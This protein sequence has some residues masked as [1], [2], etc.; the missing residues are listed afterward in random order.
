MSKFASLI[1]MIGVT[2]LVAGCQPGPGLSG[3]PAPSSDIRL[4]HDVDTIEDVVPRSATLEM[5]LRSQ[6]LSPDFTA[7]FVSAVREEFNPR[8]LRANQPYRITRTLDGLFREFRYQI[9]ADNFLRVLARRDGEPD[10]AVEVVPY[11]KEIV[12]DAAFAEI[13]RDRP[14]LIAAL[15]AEGETQLLALDLANVFGGLV[16][17]NS[18][19]QQGDRIQVLFDRVLRNGE[20]TGY[21][22][23]QAAVLENDGRTFTAFPFPQKDGTL[24]WY[25]GDG[26]SLK[27]RFLKSPLP[28]PT[29]ITSGFSYRHLHPVARTFRAHPAIDYRAPYG[30]RVVSVADG[31]VVFAAHSG[32]SGRLVRIRH[33]G[34]YESLYLHLSAFG[35]GIKPGVKVSQGQVIGRVGNSGTVTAT[36]LDYRLRKNGAY[37]NPL[38]EHSRM[39][40]G[41]PIPADEL[42]AFMAERDRLL[43]DLAGRRTS[44]ANRRAH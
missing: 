9:D 16:D 29:T 43:A 21:D 25:D 24:G 12:A 31:T 30:E 32:A 14:S 18:D 28:F 20:F 15:N 22:R 33:A 1:G 27:R 10:F 42:E 39:P 8:K 7:S 40:P 38:R 44:T 35:P 5:L 13:T 6:G 34:G 2:G 26:R 19:L 41:D 37:V 3:D 4:A 17:F 11:P 23:L 36:H